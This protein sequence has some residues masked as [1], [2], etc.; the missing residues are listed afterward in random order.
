MMFQVKRRHYTDDPK[1]PWRV[2]APQ[3]PSDEAARRAII[4]DWRE[5][6]TVAPLEWDE[7]RLMAFA[8][9]P[10]TPEVAKDTGLGDDPE[11]YGNVLYTITQVPGV[12][13]QRNGSR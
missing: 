10:L 11:P 13:A 6:E 2:V 9:W 4:A 3:E 8:R 5:M 1:K 7:A 12:P